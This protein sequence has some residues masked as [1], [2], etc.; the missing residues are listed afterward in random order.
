M[1]SVSIYGGVR[2]NAGPQPSSSEDKKRQ[3]TT[4]TETRPKEFSTDTNYGVQEVLVIAGNVET[5]NGEKT[6]K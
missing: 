4:A 6:Q 5:Q 2:L 1:T 3:I